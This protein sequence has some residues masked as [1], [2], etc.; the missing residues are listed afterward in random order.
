MIYLFIIY[1]IFSI[2]KKFSKQRVQK[3]TI[4]PFDDKQCYDN[5]IKS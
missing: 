3:S 4:S 1:F 2:L 5:N